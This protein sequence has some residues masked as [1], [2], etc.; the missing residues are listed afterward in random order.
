M[1][2]EVSI[3]PNLVAGAIP[4]GKSDVGQLLQL[5]KLLDEDEEGLV[6]VVPLQKELLIR[7][8][9]LSTELLMLFPRSN[10]FNSNHSASS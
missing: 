5:N 3:V 9:D 8:H 1:I 4:T 6:V 10:S 7:G 2:L